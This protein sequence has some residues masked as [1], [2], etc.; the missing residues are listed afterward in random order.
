MSRSVLG[1]R[2]EDAAV[3]YL[4]A[5]GWRIVA[6]NFRRREGEIDVVAEKQD[7][8]AFVEVKTRM[9]FAFGT[10]GEAV[11]FRKQ[12]RI[13]TL[14]RRFLLESALHPRI[15]RFDVVEVVPRGRTARIVHIE[16]AF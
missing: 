8:L 5:N 9:S 6:R 7:V 3:R 13:R 2:G 16:A 15:V 4:E 11:T 10:P 14:A 12:A 1:A